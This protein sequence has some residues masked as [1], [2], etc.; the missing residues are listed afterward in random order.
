MSILDDLQI[1]HKGDDWCIVG[2]V[3]MGEINNLLSVIH[4]K[5]KK[6]EL[7]THCLQFIFHGYNGFRWPVAYYGCNPAT[8]HHLWNWLKQYSSYMMWLI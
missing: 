6:V 5:G 8:T 2:G 7:A 1:V 3:D 4:N